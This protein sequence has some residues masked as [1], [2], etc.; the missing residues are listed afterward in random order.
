MLA[1]KTRFRKSSIPM[2]SQPM[3]SKP[4]TSTRLVLLFETRED[5][6]HQPTSVF[7]TKTGEQPT[8]MSADR[9]NRHVQFVGNLFVGVTQEELFDDLA[10]TRRQSQIIP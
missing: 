2:S 5:L 8:Q 9:W 6:N 1:A 7:N 3:S 4:M 10:L